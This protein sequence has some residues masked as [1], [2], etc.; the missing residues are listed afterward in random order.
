MLTC[1]RAVGEIVPCKRGRHRGGKACA[2][3]ASVEGAR[4]VSPLT[5]CCVC[6]MKPVRFSLRRGRIYW[7][8]TPFNPKT[9]APTVCR[10]CALC[11]FDGD[12]V[13]IYHAIGQNWERVGNVHFAVIYKPEGDTDRTLARERSEQIAREWASAI[14][15]CQRRLCA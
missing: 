5:L 9:A 15:K 7:L 1:G 6:A 2:E 3:A 13:K 14:G 4:G 11:R 12:F 8:F 10:C